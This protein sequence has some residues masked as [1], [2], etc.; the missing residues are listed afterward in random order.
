MQ[1]NVGRYT[2]VLVREGGFVGIGA[3]ALS[4]L[5]FACQFRIAPLKR[6][7]R[8]LHTYVDGADGRR[9]RHV[10]LPFAPEESKEAR[11]PHG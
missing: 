8:T 5:F 4:V 9:P 3:F 1:R 11:T 2:Y 6:D 7:Q 10:R